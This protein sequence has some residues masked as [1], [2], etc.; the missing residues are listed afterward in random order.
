MEISK[1]IPLTYGIASI[2]IWTVVFTALAIPLITRVRY[3][4][5][6]EIREF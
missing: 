2:I 4:P 3:R 5:P 1:A 6:E